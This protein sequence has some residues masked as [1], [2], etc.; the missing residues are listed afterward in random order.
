MS[1]KILFKANNA[2]SNGEMYVHVDQRTGH[3][4]ASYLNDATLLDETECPKTDRPV[5]EDAVGGRIYRHFKGGRYLVLL[6]GRDRATLESVVIYV[7]LHYG[8]MWVRRLDEWCDTVD[9]DGV[10]QRRFLPE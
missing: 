4:W 5:S 2:D 8:T 3:V 7:S 9:R 6:L 1:Q 10:V